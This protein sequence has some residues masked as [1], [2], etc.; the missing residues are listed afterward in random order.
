MDPE[1]QKQQDAL[2]RLHE[3][4]FKER[5][6]LISAP[7][8][9]AETYLP[10][11]EQAIEDSMKPVEEK[12][13]WLHPD[14]I[15]DVNPCAEIPA[16]WNATHRHLKTGGL[17]TFLYEGIDENSMTRV[18]IYQDRQGVVWVRPAEQFYDGR[19]EVLFD[20]K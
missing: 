15:K 10:P 11:H 16:R 5:E 2:K 9:S 1:L 7:R 8:K 14:N 4:M 20:G 6:K 13:M 18:V 17:Y 12:P 19:F 3:Q